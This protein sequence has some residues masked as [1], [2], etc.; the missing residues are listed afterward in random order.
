MEKT[1]LCPL[2]QSPVLPLRSALAHLPDVL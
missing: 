1:S 2:G